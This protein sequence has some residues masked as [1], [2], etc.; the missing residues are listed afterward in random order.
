LGVAAIVVLLAF[1]RSEWESGSRRGDHLIVT[2]Y[3]PGLSLTLD[4]ASPVDGG[5]YAVHFGI[6]SHDALKSSS[7]MYHTDGA[8]LVDGKVSTAGFGNISYGSGPNWWLVA[9]EFAM[10]AC[11][12]FALSRVLGRRNRSGLAHASGAAGTAL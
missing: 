9:C 10:V 6:F 8:R 11:T 1:P 5:W 7:G 12:V 4:G 2:F 3:S